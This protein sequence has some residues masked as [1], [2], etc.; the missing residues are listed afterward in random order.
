MESLNGGEYGI[1]KKKT[2]STEFKTAPIYNITEHIFYYS[3]SQ[4]VTRFERFFLCKILMFKQMTIV[5]WEEKGFK[6]KS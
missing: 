2:C 3:K 1:F 6:F 5:H 4:K